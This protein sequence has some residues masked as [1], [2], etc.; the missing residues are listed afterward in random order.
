MVFNKRFK[1]D[2][3][4]KILGVAKEVGLATEVF[5]LVG[6]PFET[7]EDLCE[8]LRYA[9]ELDPDF[10]TVS[11]FIPFP[12][13]GLAG[14]KDE[15]D[16]EKFNDNSYVGSAPGNDER[17]RKILAPFYLRFY[18]SPRR[19]FRVCKIL[20]LYSLGKLVQAHVLKNLLLNF[21]TKLKNCFT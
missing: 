13:V 7:E 2:D 9:E 3:V 11:R 19:F 18:L 15:I 17:M 21:W 6:L 14:I 5:I 8:T 10:V 12:G 16:L 1:L 20:K 4:K